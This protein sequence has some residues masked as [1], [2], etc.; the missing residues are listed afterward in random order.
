[1]KRM[2]FTAAIAWSVLTAMG[3][4]T[5]IVK[6]KNVTPEK[7][8][9]TGAADETAQ[10]GHAD[11]AQDFVTKNFRYRSMCDWQAG[12]RFMVIPEK[13]DLIVN[14][15]R[16]ATDQKEIPNGSLRHKVM[17]YQDHTVG[18]NGRARM[19]FICQDDNRACY[20]E[21][22]FGA[23]EDYCYGKTGVPTLAY[24]EDV[25]K[26]RELLLGQTLI[27]RQPVFYIDTQYEGDGVEEVTIPENTEVRVTQIGVGT[28]KYPVKII[29]EDVRTGREFFQNVVMSRTNSGMR[30]EELEMDKKVLFLN[31]F[32]VVSDVDQVSSDYQKYIGRTIYS[33]YAIVMLSKG[34]GKLR[35]VKVPRLTEFIIDDIVP[36]GRGGMVLMTLTESESRRVY[37][38]EV[39]FVNESMLDDN[40]N[41]FGYLFGLGE[42]K[43]RNSSRETRA[44]IRQGRVGHG[45]TQE[46]V[47]L[48]MGE[49]DAKMTTSSGLEEWHYLRTKI[50]L[51]IQF[52][53]HGKVS[54]IV[55]S[56]DKKPVTKKKKK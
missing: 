19:N 35:N 31:S 33:K 41:Y 49:P 44:M 14:T 51:I 32:E 53:K 55:K 40:E 2:L 6:T 13:Y 54:G 37:Q 5:Y 25:D 56:G 15:F 24:L 45:M 34:D 11:E 21:L 9:V 38:K 39:S 26:A 48:A 23:F 1:M 8:E 4:G 52:D 27:T 3:Q 16:D 30:D 47:E 50:V 10:E 18:E 12:M 46:E 36:T 17:V 22:P 43:L 7:A 28:R 42:G 20:F 29:V